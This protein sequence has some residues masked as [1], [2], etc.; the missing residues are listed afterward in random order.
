MLSKA[1]ERSHRIISVTLFFSILLYIVLVTFMSA[2]SVDK[3]F[4]NPCWVGDNSLLFSRNSVS[5]FAIIFS[6]SFE[7]M[8]SIEIGR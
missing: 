8:E 7:R 1:L 6:N 5:W 3:F 2:V 4:L